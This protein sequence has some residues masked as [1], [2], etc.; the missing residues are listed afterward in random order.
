VTSPPHRLRRRFWVLALAGAVAA[1]G[2]YWGLRPRPPEPPA[3]DTDGLDPEVASAIETARAGVRSAPRSARAW[4]DLGILLFAHALDPPSLPCF[5][6]AER[7]DPSDPRWPYYQGLIHLLDRPDRA[8]EYLDRAVERAGR[9]VAPRVRRAEALLALDRWDEA[10][11][12]FEDVRARQPD[13]PRAAL[14][15]AQLAARAGEWDRCVALLTPVTTEPSCRRA[16][17]GLLAEAAARRGDATAAAVHRAA[18]EDLPPDVSWDDPY[19]EA[20]KARQRGLGRRLAWS[21]ELINRGQHP[22][23]EQ[24]LR[25]I[26]ATHPK[27]AEAYLNLG[28]LY[29]GTGDRRRAAIALSEYLALIPN[30]PVG[31]FL[32]GSVRFEQ[33]D[34]VRAEES[35]RTATALQPDYAPAHF[36]FGECRRKKNDT[37]AAI[38]AYREAVRYRP[39]LVEAHIALGSALLNAGEPDAARAHLLNALRLKPDDPEMAR[40]LKQSERR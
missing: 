6:E 34:L 39:N 17:R 13:H 25:E 7:L 16:A 26:L 22:E 4:G 32:L 9:Q 20:A 37:R 24:I 18:L 33:G 27:Y 31:H 8:L 28:K 1:G 12:G 29:V 2:V 5:A 3:V 11:A 23:A 35:F 30:S 14:G 10:R 21:G 15:L 40:L 19:L 38:A 36:Y